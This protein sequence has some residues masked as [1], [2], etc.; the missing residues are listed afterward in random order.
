MTFTKDELAVS[1]VAITA[2][3]TLTNIALKINTLTGLPST[4]T[5]TTNPY[6]YLQFTSTRIVESDLD[7]AVI[8]FKVLK[9]WIANNDIDEDKIS[10]NRWSNSKWNELPTTRTS[11]DSSNYIYEA[12]T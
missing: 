2:E 11:E 6:K 7:K 10:L 8:K 1:S 3:N 5:A 4:V 12:E 9:S